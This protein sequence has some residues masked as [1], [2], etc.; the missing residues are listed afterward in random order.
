MAEAALVAGA[1]FSLVP[2]GP[3]V[4]RVEKA[5]PGWG[6]RDRKTGTRKRMLYLTCRI[7]VGDYAG[8]RLFLPLNVTGKRP[9]PS[10]A[11]YQAWTVSMDR[12]PGIGERMPF[13]VFAGKVFRVDVETV[14]LDSR[15]KPRPAITQYSRV[16]RLLELLPL[17]WE[18]PS[19]QTGDRKPETLNPTPPFPQESDVLSRTSETV[20]VEHRQ[21][22]G[23]GAAE[24]QEQ[25][26]Q[27]GGGP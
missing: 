25:V 1:K 20:G 27:P 2:S 18:A 6:W 19:P 7:L 8:T 11:F 16:A 10:S 12:P 24:I 15:G 21:P 17:G 26:I 5:E 9:R 13:T 3:Y 22:G 14:T 4:V 23:R